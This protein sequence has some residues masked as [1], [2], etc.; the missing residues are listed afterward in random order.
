MRRSQ[1]SA[2][3]QHI[4]A[5]RAGWV[6]VV[7]ALA[8]VTAPAFADE[9]PAPVE[10]AASAKARALELFAHSE[11]RYQSGDFAESARLLEQAYE[12][13]PEPVLLYNLARAREQAGEIER[14]IAAYEKYLAA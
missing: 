7:P 10:D 3:G 1:P 13:F 2:A 12:I 4:M 5:A 11:Q 8:C 6:G 9:P 14:A